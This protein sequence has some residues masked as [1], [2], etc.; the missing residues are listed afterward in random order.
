MVPLQQ[1]MVISGRATMRFA[2]VQPH[3]LNVPTS[4][5]ASFME[6]SDDYRDEPAWVAVCRGENVHLQWPEDLQKLFVCNFTPGFRVG[7]YVNGHLSTWG[8]AFPA[9]KRANIP[10]LI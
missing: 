6:G 4:S 1:A 8:K 10:L 9:F 2:F 3:R 5:N 7:T